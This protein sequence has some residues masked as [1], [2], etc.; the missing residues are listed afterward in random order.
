MPTGYDAEIHF[1]DEDGSVRSEPAS[2]PQPEQP[3]QVDWVIP[4]ES[5]VRD[6]NQAAE[7]A[8]LATRNL[9]EWQEPLRGWGAIYAEFDDDEEPACDDQLGCPCDQCRVSH[10]TGRPR[11]VRRTRIHRDRSRQPRRR[12]IF[13]LYENSECNMSEPINKFARQ[14]QICLNYRYV[15]S[16]PNFDDGGG[17]F[18]HYKVWLRYNNKLVSLYF[19]KGNDEPPCVSEIL[20]CLLSDYRSVADYNTWQTWR[21]SDFCDVMN[22]DIAKRSFIKLKAQAERFADFMGSR[23][24]TLGEVVDAAA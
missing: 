18:T 2:P 12:S 1:T 23:L 15:D 17:S 19:S 14:N 7:Y 24:A 13:R 10:Q 5:R 20:E 6:L 11:P 3:A 9:Y 4:Q 21:N 16:N 8:N 22:A